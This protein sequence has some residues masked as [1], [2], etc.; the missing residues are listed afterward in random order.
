MKAPA[1]PMR[2]SPTIPNPVPCTIWPASHPAMRPTTN[3]IRR[4]SPDMCIFVSSSCISK[5]T[6][7]RPLRR[8]EIHHQR[9]ARPKVTHHFFKEDWEPPSPASE[10]PMPSEDCAKLLT[11]RRSADLS[12]CRCDAAARLDSA[13][14][15][16]HGGCRRFRGDQDCQK[17]SVDGDHTMSNNNIETIERTLSTLMLAGNVHFRP[18]A[19][20]RKAVDQYPPSGVKHVQVNRIATAAVKA[21]DN[22]RMASS[23]RC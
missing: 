8:R 7:F 17:A 23:T 13:A 5:L 16:L 2:R 4:L 14:C 9:R 20:V 3:M 11:L 18:K 21:T 12:T 19:D 10:A 22:F 6:N 15:S 1:I